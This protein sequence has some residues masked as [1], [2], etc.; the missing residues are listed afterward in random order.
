MKTPDTNEDIDALVKK[1]IDETLSTMLRLGTAL[2]G[3]GLI[4]DHGRPASMVA[5]Y[6]RLLGEEIERRT[7][8]PVT[9]SLPDDNTTVLANAPTYDEPVFVAYVEAGIWY[10]AQTGQPLAP[11][12]H[13]VAF[14]R[15]FPAEP[16]GSHP[17]HPSYPSYPSNPSD[18][19]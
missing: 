12:D 6:T 1:A 17:L 10:D 16:H 9:K 3:Y 11:E 8:T 18:P 19:K 5:E 14:W 4:D 13:P 2:A 7:W 15:H